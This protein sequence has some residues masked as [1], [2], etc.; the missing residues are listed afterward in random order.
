MDAEGREVIA[1]EVW[2]PP[3]ITELPI[4]C[5]VGDRSIAQSYLHRGF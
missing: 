1:V 5:F 3:H 2:M 4:N